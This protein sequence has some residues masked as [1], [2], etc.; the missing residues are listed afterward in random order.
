MYLEPVDVIQIAKCRYQWQKHVEN[1]SHMFYHMIYITGGKG[2]IYADKTKYTISANEIYF[3]AP[4]TEHE[5]ITGEDAM[6]SI[7]VK[8][9]V[10]DNE[11][12]EQLNNLNVK[13]QPPD[14]EFKLK[15]EGLLE[16]AVMKTEYYKQMINIGAAGIMLGLLRGAQSRTKIIHMKDFALNENSKTSNKSTKEL[17]RVLEYINNNYVEEVTLKNLSDV[18]NLNSA[19]LCK[20]FTKAYHISPIQYVNNLRIEKSKEMI[21]FTD[22]SIT[23][24]SVA[25]GFQSVHY[26]SR[27]F[28]KKE[29]MSPMEFKHYL[30]E[31]MYISVAE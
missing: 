20:Q 22:L 30:N 9:H 27:Y 11:I 19:Y 6:S 4:G 17:K 10:N 7:E 5:L 25:V 3:F 14:D 13:L 28:K 8:F 23:E 26:F 2:D 15:L 24:I 29:K 12:M 18:A 31:C 21:T 1:H 16:E